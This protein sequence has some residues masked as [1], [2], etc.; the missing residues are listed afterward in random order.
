MDLSHVRSGAARTMTALAVALA[1]CSD[2]GTGPSGRQILAD[3][4]FAQDINEIFQRRGCSAGV[5]HGSGQAGLVL[6]GDAASN[7]ANLVS[8]PATSESFLR[9]DPGDAQDSYIVIKVEGR[10]AVGA[11]MPFGGTPLDDIDVTN[12]RNWIDNGAPNN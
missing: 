3:P 10:Q 1:A 5:C 4:S 7:Y 2:D 12:L 6:T 8:V 9:V 11:Q